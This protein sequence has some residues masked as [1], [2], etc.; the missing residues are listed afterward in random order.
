MRKSI[1][2]PC[3][4]ELGQDQMS[5]LIRAMAFYIAVIQGFFPGLLLHQRERLFFSGGA[6]ARICPVFYSVGADRAGC[7]SQSGR[8]PDH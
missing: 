7:L 8:K 6:K 1:W 3:G 4:S 2:I 5:C